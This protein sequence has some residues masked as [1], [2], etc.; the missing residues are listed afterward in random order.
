M[1]RNVADAHA[2]LDTL[3]PKI[4]RLETE[5]H[6]QFKELFYRLKRVETFLI[7]GCGSI[8]AMLASVL[9]RMG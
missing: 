3:E 5:N 8:I 2:R 6:I 9:I 1:S 4:A 7:I